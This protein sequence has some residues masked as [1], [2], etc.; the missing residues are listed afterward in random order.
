MQVGETIEHEFVID[1]EK[2]R[3]FISVSGDHNPL[4]TS[5]SF[6]QGKGFQSIVMHG[7]ILNCFVSFLVGELLPVKNVLILCQDIKYNKPVYLDEVLK[8]K[9]TVKEYFE[10]VPGYEIK[11]DFINQTSGEKKA[12]GNVL[13]KI[14]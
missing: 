9:A 6:A 7:N 8:I 13:I 2:H 1:A 11:F 4:H 3:A 12:S 5:E 10:F 14:I